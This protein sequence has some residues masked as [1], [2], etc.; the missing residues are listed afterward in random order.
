M[1]FV[2]DIADPKS[3][4]VSAKLSNSIAE[5]IQYEKRLTL[6]SEK[7]KLLKVNSR[8]RHGSLSVNGEN[9]KSV[10]VSR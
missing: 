7:C 8:C 2:D 10:G 3:D 4:E 6:S 1:E 5:Q 9:K